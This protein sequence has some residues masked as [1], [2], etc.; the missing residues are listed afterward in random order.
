MDRESI[1]FVVV[2][3]KDEE[4]TAL[5]FWLIREIRTLRWNGS[6]QLAVCTDARVYMVTMNS[7]GHANRVLRQ[8]LALLTAGR[9]VAIDADGRISDLGPPRSGTG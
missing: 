4:T 7:A 2:G 6:W 5:P 8:V 1:G 9:S 3:V